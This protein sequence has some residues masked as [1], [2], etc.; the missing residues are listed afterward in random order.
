M[1]YEQNSEVWPSMQ[2]WTANSLL[3]KLPLSLHCVCLVREK[4]KIL[5]TWE[6][7]LLQEFIYF[8]ISSRYRLGQAQVSFFLD[9]SVSKGTN[10]VIHILMYIYFVC[11]MLKRF[12]I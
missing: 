4:E 6:M 7:G 5:K 10:L 1:V 12:V 3:N 9:E 2:C 11:Q 8:L